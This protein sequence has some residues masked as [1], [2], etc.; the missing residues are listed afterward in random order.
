[1]L[2][3][4][5]NHCHSDI[6]KKYGIIIIGGD[7]MK[8]YLSSYRV[9]NE[10][11]EL[12]KWKQEH[13][14]KIFVIPN[15]VDVFPDGER[16][17]SGIQDKCKD[18]EQLGFETQ[19]LDLRNFFYHKEDLSNHIKDVNAF[20]VIGGN[21][22][23]LRTAMKLSGFDEI[24][25]D[26]SKLENYLYSGFSAGICVLAKDLHGI[27]LADSYEADPYNYQKT[28]WEGIGL[29]DYM[30]VPHFDTQN[31]PESPLMYDVVK[32]L[33]ENDLKYKTLHDGEVLIEDTTPNKNLK[34]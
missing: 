11:N 14:N 25:V 12:L 6:G 4:A 3:E 5:L 16:K 19:I 17:T 29:I 31:H 34:R 10:T 7:I 15:A 8:L 23:V 28:I 9:G 1:M 21:V 2:L 33:E 20:Y 22:F 13:G 32:Y 24:L 27:H 30:P 26:L 18:L